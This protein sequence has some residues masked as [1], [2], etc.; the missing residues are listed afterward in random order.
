[1]YILVGA[2]LAFAGVTT[3]LV[4]LDDWIGRR[5]VKGKLDFAQIIFGRNI[6]GPGIYLG[7]SLTSR[8][9][10]P[11]DL[12]FTEVRTRIGNQVP[13]ETKFNNSRFTVSPTGLVWFNDHIINIAN[14]P[15]PGTLE[16]FAEFR[17]KYGRHGNMKHDLTVKKSVV[18]KFNS[19]GLLEF[20]SWNDAM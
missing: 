17:I 7:V 5:R 20:G 14:V 18:V 10:I 2:G 11:M 9:A 13:S 16:G 15:T 19:D 8:A 6:N 4:R 12:Y 1:M 3:G